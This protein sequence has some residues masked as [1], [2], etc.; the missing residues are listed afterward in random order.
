M[1]A[2]VNVAIGALVDALALVAATD[3][4]GGGAALDVTL[5]GVVG[6][7]VVTGTTE[8]VHDDQT[9]LETAAG[10]LDTGAGAGAE[11]DQTAHEEELTTT[12]FV[13]DEATTGF[14]VDEEAAGDQFDHDEDDTGTTGLLE[15]TVVET[16]GEDQALQL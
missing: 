1:A 14:V 4:D 8:V 10:V 3:V 6:T 9:E 7:G 12:G 11:D 16:A 13:V 2:P 5:I 15:E